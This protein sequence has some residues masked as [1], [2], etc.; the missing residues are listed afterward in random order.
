MAKNNLP[1]NSNDPG[2]DMDLGHDRDA[3]QAT[4]RS[5]YRRDG[6]YETVMGFAFVWA[7]V[8]MLAQLSSLFPAAYAEYGISAIYIV[9]LVPGVFVAR[10]WRKRVTFRRL[11]FAEVAFPWHPGMSDKQKWTQG[12]QTLL[13]LVVLNIAVGLL[14]RDYSPASIEPKFD[15]ICLQN[16]ISIGLGFGIVWWGLR[17]L[18]GI[19]ALLLGLLAVARYL[20]MNPGWA[21]GATG[22]LML[23][24]GLWK[25]RR[26]L[27]DYPVLEAAD[28]E[29]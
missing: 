4:F 8:A 13:V 2:Q 26:F 7:G 10:V 14:L 24:I 19:A 15:P 5:D 11:G 22:L 3:L 29:E 6:L 1:L 16:L 17:H 18:W 25:L 27:R 9:G 21:I 23:I 12:L 28:G 20:P